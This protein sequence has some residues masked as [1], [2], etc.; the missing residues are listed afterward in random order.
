MVGIGGKQRNDLIDAIAKAVVIA[1]GRNWPDAMGGSALAG[2]ANGPLLLTEPSGAPG[3][4]LDEVRRLGATQVY[5]LGSEASVSSAVV[6]QLTSIVGASGVIRIAGS[7]RYATSALV[8][9][10]VIELN[11]AYDGMAF[12]A[13][14]ANFPDALAAAP[15]AAHR[16]W[17]V[18][19]ANPNGTLTVPEAVTSAVI[20]GGE[21]SVSSGIEGGLGGLLGV[22]NVIR[23]AGPDR[24]ATSALVAAWGVGE[25]LHWEGVGL[26]TGATFADALSGGVMLGHLRSPLLLT[27]GDVLLSSTRAPLSINKQSVQ[28]VRFFGGTTTISNDVRM[29]VMQALQ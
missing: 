4:V 11:P 3:I 1:T 27:R 12:V 17:P 14:G 20:V 23:K 29:Q 13:T 10:K 2:V 22:E 15:I 28:T 8:A 7:N 25:G 5:V 21:V 6:N 16:G 26:A 19:L 24:Y 18:L 9:E